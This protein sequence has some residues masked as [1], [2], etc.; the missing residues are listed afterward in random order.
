MTQP[1]N[2]LI[3]ENIF[4]IED[5]QSLKN[6]LLFDQ[7]SAQV[8]ELI[9]NDFE[10]LISLL[11]RIDVSEK[12][13]KTLLKENISADSAKIIATLI[14]DRQI[15]K[16]RSRQQNSPGNDFDENERW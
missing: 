15:Q 4:L 6:K 3:T 2:Q 7:L 13:L 5:E 14:I 11:Y 1:G 10:R 9:N 8:N 16:I 12:K